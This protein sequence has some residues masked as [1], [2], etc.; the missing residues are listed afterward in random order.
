MAG[1]QS[2]SVCSSTLQAMT[3]DGYPTSVFQHAPWDCED[4]VKV[5]ALRTPWTLRDSGCRAASG[6]ERKLALRS[7]RT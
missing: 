2:A 1:H 7:G 6:P 4:H 3:E 5:W